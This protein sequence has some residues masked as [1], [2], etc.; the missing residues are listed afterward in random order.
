MKKNKFLIPF[1][2]LISALIFSGCSGKK[3]SVA[4][5]DVYARMESEVNFP[6]H[7]L[8]MDG[9]YF[10]MQFGF[11]LEDFDQYIYSQGE[12]ILLAETVIL[13]K[14]KNGSDMNKI[15]QKLENFVSDQT[16]VFNSYIPEQGK[17]AEKS[18]VE[19]KGNYAYL[20]MSSK[21]SELKKI[22]QEMI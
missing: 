11:N 22:A 7:M 20:L 21:V 3:N 19:V 8:K 13:I 17:V 5:E 14:A 10:V 4:I 18:V 1:A 6:T 9:D 12:D 16:T 2:M 15:K